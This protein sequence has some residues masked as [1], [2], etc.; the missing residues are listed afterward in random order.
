LIDT[1][2]L[3]ESI[4]VFAEDPPLL[5][6]AQTEKASPLKYSD[7]CIMSRITEIKMLSTVSFASIFS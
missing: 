1:A 2:S 6:T 3:G 5:Y 4:S 7:I